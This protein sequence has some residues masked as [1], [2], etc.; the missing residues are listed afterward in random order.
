[1]F[2]SVKWGSSAISGLVADE[3]HIKTGTN[4]FLRLDRS[5]I[6][7]PFKGSPPRS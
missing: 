2:T 1:M 6:V 4:G 5:S 3:L 7:P